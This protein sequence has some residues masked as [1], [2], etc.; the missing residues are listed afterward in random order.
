[1][2]VIETDAPDMAVHQY[3]EGAEARAFGKPRDAN[4]HSAGTP[5]HVY[6]LDGWSHFDEM[7]GGG[8]RSGADY[9]DAP[10]FRIPEF[11]HFFVVPIVEENGKPT[12]G[13]WTAFATSQQAAHAGRAA[14][15]DHKGLIVVA[16]E[17]VVE[18]NENFFEPIAI[19]GDVPDFL[20]G[21]L[22]GL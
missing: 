22:Q 18:G 21:M 17:Q 6:W 8:P 19:I 15:G 5:E 1:M 16:A 20:L 12:F 10:L 3:T 4:P 11:R 13:E 14:A 9:S 2:T 7:N